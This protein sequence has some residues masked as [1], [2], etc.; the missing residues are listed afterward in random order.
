M[1]FKHSEILWALFLLIIPI[2]IHLFQLR[3]FQKVA[4]TNVKFLKEVTIQTRKSSELKK[5][6]I[7][8]SRI[9]A[10]TAAIIAF[11]QPYFANRNVQTTS[12]ETVVYLDNSFSMQLRGAKGP[13]LNRAIQELINGVPEEEEIT[14]FTNNKSFAKNNI[15]S[16]QNQLLQLEYTSKQLSL[17]EII[18]KGQNSFQKNTNS[19]K[20]LVIVSDFQQKENYNTAN[21]DSLISIEAVKTR[22]VTTDNV[23]LDSVYISKT[24]PTNIEIIAEVSTSNTITGSYPISLFND[25]KLVAKVAA[26]FNDTKETSV[27][28][29]IPANTIIN[30]HLSIDNDG[31]QYDNTIYFNIN[32]A[33]KINVLSINEGAAVFLN[34]IFTDDEFNLINYKLNELDYSTIEKQNLIILNE[35][36][37]IPTSLS[38]ALNSFHSKGGKII[39]IPNEK[40]SNTS[41]NQFLNYL[42]VKVLDTISSIEKKITKINFSHTIYQDVFDKE[43]SNFQYPNISKHLIFDK[44]YTSLLDYED[45]NSFLFEKNGVYIFSAPLNKNTSNFKNS[46]LIVP[47]FYSIA[48]KSLQ[49]PELYHYIGNEN[50]IDVKAALNQE[51]VLTVENETSQFIPLQQSFPNRVRLSFNENP[52]KSGIYNIKNQAITVQK[53]SFNYPRNESNLTYGNPGDIGIK[54]VNESVSLFFDS[55]KK[56][57]HISELWKWFVTFALLFLI[58]ELLLLKYLK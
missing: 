21:L 56:E 48:K 12:K 55:L 42:S 30:G 18:L 28:F 40:A 8:L 14:V 53:I 45:G 57:S 4:F 6:L 54:T 3:R 52:E 39:I 26:E 29:S 35:L 31:L 7:L 33:E 19:I 41:Y 15:K 34:R 24:T 20:K 9:L 44:K 43:I 17:D 22:P 10:L 32:K 2:L 16:I 46:P 50:Q 38:T 36:E 37:N 5:W 1:Q 27:N 49:L 23:S 13:L 58:I 11:A 47:T 51:A 25:Q